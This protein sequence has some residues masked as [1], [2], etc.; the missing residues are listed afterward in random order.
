MLRST[1]EPTG[2][3]KPSMLSYLLDRP[4]LVTLSGLVFAVLAIWLALQGRPTD[5]MIAA[6]WAVLADW[7]DGCVARRVR[8][9]RPG[10]SEVGRNLDSLADMVSSGV[11]PAVLLM[12]LAQGDALPSLAGGLLCLAGAL[13][14]SFFNAFG[15]LNDGRFVGMPLPHNILVL[16]PVYA[17]SAGLAPSSA[18]TWLSV[19]VIVLAAL[20]VAPIRFPKSPDGCLPWVTIYVVGLSVCLALVV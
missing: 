3:S 19:T 11:F 12:T 9:R 15:L 20:N 2:S 7:Y 6:L 10:A 13:R 17:L 18:V 8:Q 5:A 4:N 1:V 16:G 14:L